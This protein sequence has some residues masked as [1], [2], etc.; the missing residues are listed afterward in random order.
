MKRRDFV[1]LSSVALG[2]LS[3]RIPL[4]LNT[5]PLKR[6]ASWKIY[7]DGSFDILSD[8]I[9][10]LRCYPVIDDERVTPKSFRI[11]R[12]KEGLAL[13]YDLLEG[14]VELTFRKD[15][16]SVFIETSLKGMKNAPLSVCP[17][18]NA[19]ITG[20]TRFFRQGLGFGGP[21]GIFDIKASQKNHNSSTISEQSWSYDSYLCSGLIAAD[22][23]SM[24]IGAYEHKAFLQ[25][26]TIFNS[27]HRE[28]LVDTKVEQSE[29]FLVS[30]G[31]LTEQIPVPAEGLSLPGIHIMNGPQPFVT[32]QQLA[33]NIAKASKARTDKPTMYSWDPWYEYFE[34]FDGRKLDDFLEGLK[35]IQPRIPLKAVLLTAGYCPMGDWLDAD[36]RVFTGGIQAEI[37][38]IL[39]SG[40]NAGIWIGPFMVSNKSK[41]YKE[42]PDWILKGT[43]GKPLLDSKGPKGMIDN[44][45][46]NEER[47]YLDT[48]HPDAF[49]YLRNVFRT[50]KSWGVTA[51]KTDFMDWGLKNSAEVKRTN[52]G[53]TSVQYFRDV[54]EM[55][56]QEIGDDSYML[57]CISP[58]APMIG[59]VDAVRTAYDTHYRWDHEG[60]TRNTLNETIADQYF[61]NI[62]WQN[63]PD[64]VLLRHSQ[65]NQFTD[66]EV[67]TLLYLFHMTGGAMSASDRF[68]RI[69]DYRLRLWRFAQPSS[70]TNTGKMP[71]WFDKTKKF[72]YIYKTY[73]NGNYALL[74]SNLTQEEGDESVAL[75]DILGE[76]ELHAFDWEPGKFTY[77]GLRQTISCKLKPHE[78][79]LLYMAKNKV[80][81]ALTTGLSGEP[82]KGL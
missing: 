42:H 60:P 64:V 53:K 67:K 37:S 57:G 50:F 54:V 73:D 26:T 7:E 15:D 70:K 9:S 58:F 62:F 27:A 3:M 28:G 65:S 48:S 80:A 40:Y 78:S 82:V 76:K 4:N 43:D 2:G 21:S 38:K 32:M 33:I 30:A 24:A 55:I 51:Y 12:N 61:N 49:E 44:L 41:L 56:R 45:V 5:A 46:V 20:A 25:R 13:V 19:R 71:F 16:D 10:L 69:Q 63:D 23:N 75:A 81:P 52:P 14:S 74:V 39:D 72:H 6:S 17:I 35:S 22:G 31:F 1:W 34:D 8:T 11:E 29:K 77:A 66:D 36:P 47:Y 59:I 79:R 68:H 18:G